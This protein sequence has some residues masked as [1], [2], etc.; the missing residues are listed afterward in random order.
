M[1]LNRVISNWVRKAM[2]LCFGFAL[3][4]N[5]IGV[6]LKLTSFLI[7]ARLKTK[8]NRDLGLLPLTF[9]WFWFYNTQL[10]CPLKDD[11]V[12]W[13][14]LKNR[15]NIKPLNCSSSRFWINTVLSSL[16]FSCSLHG[17][18]FFPFMTDTPS[19][20]CCNTSLLLQLLGYLR[21]ST[22]RLSCRLII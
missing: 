20:A 6:E 8:S 19:S 7:S 4:R 14:Y 10:K 21:K 3:L 12:H 17:F 9:L 15:I 18:P 11:P 16:H 1:S 13:A 2:L 5:M 22:C